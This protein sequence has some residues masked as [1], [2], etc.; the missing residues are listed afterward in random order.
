MQEILFYERNQIPQV[1]VNPDLL[2]K[3]ILLR[4]LGLPG[5]EVHCFGGQAKVICP[6]A[7]DPNKEECTNGCY[8]TKV[9]AQD[10]SAELIIISVEEMHKRQNQISRSK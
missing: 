4:A 7:T 2:G 5:Y 8:H 3:E 9:C 6:A 1:E 10:N